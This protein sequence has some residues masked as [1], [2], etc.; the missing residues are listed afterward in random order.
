[1]TQNT[2]GT[3]W[4]LLECTDAA[5][6]LLDNELRVLRFTAHAAAILHLL[7]ADTGRPLSEVSAMQQCVRLADDAR[8]TLRTSL[9]RSRLFEFPGG[10]RWVAR[11]APWPAYRH[12]TVGVVLILTDAV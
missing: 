6:V 9:T 11:C 3:T 4:H 1:M 10:C 2:S 5:I 12:G 7:P 8:Q